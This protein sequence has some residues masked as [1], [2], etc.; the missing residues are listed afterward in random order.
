L[1]HPSS[2]SPIRINKKKRI[3]KNEEG[4]VGGGGGVKGR[5][6]K[7]KRIELPRRV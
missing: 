1:L 3:K 7:W 6:K 2:R 5:R 4:G